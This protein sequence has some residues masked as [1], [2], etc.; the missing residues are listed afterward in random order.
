MYRTGLNYNNTGAQLVTG[1]IE[2]A[3]WLC[4]WANI[5]GSS[6]VFFFFIYQ[7]IYVSE[8]AGIDCQLTEYIPGRLPR[9]LNPSI[10]NF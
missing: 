7:G 3:G 1:H 2:T 10:S 5:I 6:K 8:I 9:N 4:S